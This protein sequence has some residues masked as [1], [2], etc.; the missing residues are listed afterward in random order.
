MS[1]LSALGLRDLA[2]M[3]ARTWAMS[4]EDR[5]QWFRDHPL[6][7]Y[8]EAMA[9]IRD[10]PPPKPAPRGVCLMCFYHVI[11]TW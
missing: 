8:E 5:D 1:G 2:A 3:N 7:D 4:D 9:A 10:A 6:S 11:K